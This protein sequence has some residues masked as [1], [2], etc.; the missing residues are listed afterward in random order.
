MDIG[1]RASSR[2]RILVLLKTRGPDT[3]ARLAR[4]LSLTTMAV[5]QHLAVLQGEG[6]VDYVNERRR[7]GRPAR[8]WRLTEKSHARFPDS[9]G[10]L[11]VTLLQAARSVFGDKGLG[12]LTA[13]LTA[14]QAESYREQ[15]PGPDSSIEDRVAA[16]AKIRQTEGYMAEWHRAR[17]GSLSLVENHCSIHE[18]ARACPQL[19][20][21]ELTLFRT[22]L[23][24]DVSVER[25]EHLLRGDRRCAYR[26]CHR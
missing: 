14:R 24:Q 21:R 4:Q 11:V 12:R 5:R 19:C 6:L 3:S 13:E 1:T 7:V 15:V 10:G 8:R 2:D 20:L 9:H 22:V 26:I 18:A 17:D 25:T 23:G 16:L